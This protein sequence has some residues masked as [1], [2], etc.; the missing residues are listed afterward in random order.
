LG[1]LLILVFSLGLNW[2]PPALW[3]GASHWILPALTLA[4]APATYVA[5]LTRSGL[6]DVLSQNYIRTAQAKGL[7]PY[8]VLWR[9]AMRNAIGPVITIMGPLFAWLITGSFVVE[10]IFSIP[11][12]GR[13]FVTA[14]ID[15]DYTVVMGATL[16]YAVVVVMAN[17]AVDV[18]YGV[19][20]PRLRTHE[21]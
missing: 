18:L 11:G 5:R 6:L 3:E 17:L 9:H 1:T 12:M 7:S 21:T 20:D 15:R 8:R 10:F 4:A 19:M 14:V 13:Y 2:L 16:V